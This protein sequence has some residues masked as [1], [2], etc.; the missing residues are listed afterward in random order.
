MIQQVALFALHVAGY[1]L[2]QRYMTVLS[3]SSVFEPNKQNSNSQCIVYAHYC[4]L[5][6]CHILPLQNFILLHW[7]SQQTTVA[8]IQSSCNVASFHRS[9]HIRQILAKPPFLTNKMFSS[10]TL[11]SIR[12]SPSS[13]SPSPLFSFTGRQPVFVYCD[14][15]LRKML[16]MLPSI[17]YWLLC[18]SVHHSPYVSASSFR[19]CPAPFY[20]SAEQRIAVWTEKSSPTINI[21][22]PSTIL[23]SV[24]FN[25]YPRRSCNSCLPDSFRNS[26]SVF[27]LSSSE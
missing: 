25:L 22:V 16:H 5:L 23:P 20:V 10:P 14:I 21:I 7:Y 6:L 1:S 9:E 24:F 15:I 27:T 17:P 26:G 13:K 11:L 12:Q 8:V 4:L 18:L 19:R 2:Q 3:P